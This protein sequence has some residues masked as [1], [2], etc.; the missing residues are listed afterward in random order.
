MNSSKGAA[1][2][3][4]S[5]EAVDDGLIILG[6]E[7]NSLTDTLFRLS[8][9]RRRSQR[10]MLRHVEL[11]QQMMLMSNGYEQLENKKFD[12]DEIDVGVVECAS[13]S[14]EKAGDDRRQDCRRH[15]VPL[16]SRTPENAYYSSREG[17]VKCNRQN[18]E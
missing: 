17:A 3:I 6:K 14:K 18:T 12:G 7:D 9:E 8:R 13:F 4:I 1:T 11:A 2:N 5:T 10:D 16:S 15:M